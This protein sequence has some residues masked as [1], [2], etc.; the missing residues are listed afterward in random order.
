MRELIKP[1]HH[2]SGLECTFTIAKAGGPVFYVADPAGGASF[3]SS[4]GTFKDGVLALSP[5]QAA[6]FTIS[7]TEIPGREPLRDWSMNDTLPRKGTITEQGL[8]GRAATF[9]GKKQEFDTGVKTTSLLA[10]GG[11]MAAWVKLPDRNKAR[12]KPKSGETPATTTPVAA[13]AAVSPG[14]EVI[15]G[16]HRRRTV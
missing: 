8:R 6:N 2:G 5:E 1:P 13:P 10:T 4:A 3:A 14:E 16:A 15:I 12:P 11:T 9:D 7:L